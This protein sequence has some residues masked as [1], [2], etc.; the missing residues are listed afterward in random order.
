LG[1]PWCVWHFAWCPHRPPE[2]VGPVCAVPGLLAAR[3]PVPSLSPGISARLEIHISGLVEPV[4]LLCTRRRAWSSTLVAY[5]LD[6]LVSAVTVALQSPVVNQRSCMVPAAF[7]HFGAVV[8]ALRQ[9]IELSA[10]SHTKLLD[11]PEPL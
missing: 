7:A 6:K 3:S 1:G 11:V 9:H 8:V 4:Q 5:W 2:A 10:H